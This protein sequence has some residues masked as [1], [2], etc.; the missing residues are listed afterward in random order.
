MCY[1]H[2]TRYRACV[3]HMPTHVAYVTYVLCYAIVTQACLRLLDSPSMVELQ[4]M[5]EVRAAGMKV[6][7]KGWVMQQRASPELRFIHSIYAARD[8]VCGH[9]RLWLVCFRFPLSKLGSQV[10]GNILRV[11]VS[12]LG[13]L[14]RGGTNLY[15]ETIHAAH[16]QSEPLPRVAMCSPSCCSAQGMWPWQLEDFEKAA[17][18]DDFLPLHL[19]CSSE[20]EL[21]F[22]FRL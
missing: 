6:T 2:I 3:T 11:S 20:E 12:K 9:Q 21:T 4:C 17:A 14:L 22:T 1:A 18:A 13:A 10:Q 8:V 19:G 15:A 16:L 5:S 7:A